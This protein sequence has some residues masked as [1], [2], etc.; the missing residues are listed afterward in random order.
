MTTKGIT[1][2]TIVTGDGAEITLLLTDAEIELKN[3]VREIESGDGIHRE[4]ERDR[5]VSISIKGLRLPLFELSQFEVV[6]DDKPLGAPYI[7]DVPEEGDEDGNPLPG[8]R[9]IHT[10]TIPVRRGDSR[11]Q[12]R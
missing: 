12:P 7:V 10:L 6:A 4:F 3:G 2:I 9:M 8:T 1:K 5:N 11:I